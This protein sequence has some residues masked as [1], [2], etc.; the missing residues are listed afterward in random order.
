MVK[1]LLDEYD[2]IKNEPPEDKE[3]RSDKWIRKGESPNTRL[4]RMKDA[5]LRNSSDSRCI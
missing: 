5:A 1:M 2:R 4:I 3:E